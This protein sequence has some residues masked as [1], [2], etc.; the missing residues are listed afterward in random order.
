MGKLNAVEDDGLVRSEQSTRGNSEEKSIT[1]V[2]RRSSHSDTER[3]LLFDIA[4][5]RK[6]TSDQTP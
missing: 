6:N 2:S 4:R 3:L 5:F 1:D